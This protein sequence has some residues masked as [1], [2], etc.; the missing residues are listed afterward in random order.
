MLHGFD[1][2]RLLFLQQTNDYAGTEQFL[3]MLEEKRKEALKELEDSIDK[4]ALT[5]LMY[6]YWEAE[7]GKQEI[8]ED[9]MINHHLPAESARVWLEDIKAADVKEFQQ[10]HADLWAEIAE[11]E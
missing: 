4:R 6:K 9:L 7:A 5:F 1:K 10:H 3:A 8:M 2:E 11:V